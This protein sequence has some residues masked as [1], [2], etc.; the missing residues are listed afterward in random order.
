MAKYN[1]NIVVAHNARF[2]ALSMRLTER[3]IT[4]SK[5]RYFFPYGTKFVCTLKMAR[6]VFDK[7]EEYCAFCVEN[8]YLTKYKKNRFTAEILYR[9]LS[10][11]NSF[12]ESHIGFEDTEI[13]RKIFA[14][15]LEEISLEDG[16]CGRSTV[17]RA[18]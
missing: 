16:V 15:C 8:G 10:G 9:F 18:S 14:R 7:N 17:L 5:Y 4:K 1:T 11:D 3:Y 12:E 2:D 6:K 13:E